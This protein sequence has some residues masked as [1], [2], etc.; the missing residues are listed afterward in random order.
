MKEWKLTSLDL[1]CLDMVIKGAW[2]Y[3][4]M[5]D[6]Q[7]L[8]ESLKKLIKTYPHLTGHYQ[9]KGKVL[10]WDDNYC[11]EPSIDTRNKPEFSVNDLIGKDEQ[12][13]SL[14]NDYDTKAFKKGKEMPFSATLVKLKDGAVLIVQCAH[15]T[16]DG[17]SFFHLMEQWAAL[18]KGETIKPMVVDQNQLPKKEAYTKAEAL[19]KAKQYGWIKMKATSLIKMLWDM[20]RLRNMKDTFIQLVSQ[21]EIAKLKKESGAG[22]HAVL[23]ALAAKEVMSRLQQESFKTISVSDLR[24]HVF[25]VSESLMGNLSQPFAT[26]E[27][28]SLKLDTIALAQAIQEANDAVLQSDAQDR[29]LRLSV[30]ASHYGLPYYWMDPSEVFNDRPKNLYINNQLKFRACELDFG[31]GKPLYAFPNQLSDNVKFWQPVADGPV[32]II[33]WGF[34]AKLMQTNKK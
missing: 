13:W 10:I 18:T 8:R 2:I 7:T 34:L 11:V 19:E 29:N 20:F 3:K 32:Q 30:C 12:T 14:V 4:E 33:Y 27:E 25:G 17:Y 28:F 26:Q 21:E 24:G 16:M 22:T 31:T 5:P 1:F 15:A 9:E 23:S 6:V